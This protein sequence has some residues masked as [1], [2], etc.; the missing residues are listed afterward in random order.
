[1]SYPERYPPDLALIQVQVIKASISVKIAVA[2][3]LPNQQ[4]ATL[5]RAMLIN[6]RIARNNSISVWAE[7]VV[8]VCEAPCL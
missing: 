5:R 6:S 3:V 4:M 8:L 7:E 2:N 1:M